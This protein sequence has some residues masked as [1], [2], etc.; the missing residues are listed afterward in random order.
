MPLS[1]WAGISTLTDDPRRT[2]VPTCSSAGWVTGTSNAVPSL[3]AEADADEADLLMRNH[4]VVA[5]C[6]PTSTGRTF[7]RHRDSERDAAGPPC[8]GLTTRTAQMGAEPST[9]GA[10][11]VTPCGEASLWSQMTH[12]QTPLPRMDVRRTFWPVGPCRLRGKWQGPTPSGASEL[13]F[14]AVACPCPS[15]QPALLL[16]YRKRW[17]TSAVPDPTRPGAAGGHRSA[18]P[19]TFPR[20]CGASSCPG[21]FAETQ[22]RRPPGTNAGTR[23]GRS[24]GL[25]WVSAEDARLR[26]RPAP[27]PP[28]TPRRSPRTLQCCC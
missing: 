7:S 26:C 22:P 20:M 27:Q 3:S 6:P 14:G 24:I 1:G 17:L 25:Y 8:F 23:V 12:R 4:K 19:R 18:K 28:A 21:S 9:S 10:I 16:S 13:P 11:A 2:D 15:D 5:V